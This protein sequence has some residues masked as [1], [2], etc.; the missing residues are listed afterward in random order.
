MHH[1]WSLQS[2]P[3]LTG[4]FL[5]FLGFLGKYNPWQYLM[6]YFIVSKRVKLTLTK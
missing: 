6:F 3:L 4:G 5:G 2:A 1:L